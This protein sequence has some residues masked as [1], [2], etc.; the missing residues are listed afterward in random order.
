MYQVVKTYGHDLGISACFRQWRAKSHCAFLHGYALSFQLTFESATLND[1]NWV[2][3]FGGLKEIKELIFGCFDHKLLVAE[4]D[5][6]LDTISSLA[7]LGIADVVVLPATGCEAF[8]LY[9]AKE[10]ERW[11]FEHEHG[12]RVRLARL[13]VAEHSGN[14]ATYIAGDE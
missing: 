13:T 11:L 12:G 1:Q 14:A 4:D 9:V 2:I 6:E 5:P 8:A 3:D 10:I 7:G